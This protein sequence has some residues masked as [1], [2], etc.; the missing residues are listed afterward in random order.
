MS[1]ECPNYYNSQDRQLYEQLV[2]E[3]FKRKLTEK[4]R[5]FI[6]IMYHQEEFDAGL[7]GD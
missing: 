7:D 4:E 2:N 5:H 3:S 1:F 6:N